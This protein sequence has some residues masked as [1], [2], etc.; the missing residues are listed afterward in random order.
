MNTPSV[1]EHLLPLDEGW[2]LWREFCVRGAGFPATDVLRLACPLS[3]ATSKTML[4]VEQWVNE[5]E[6]DFRSACKAALRESQERGERERASHLRAQ[7]KRSIFQRSPRETHLD[8]ALRARIIN[9]RALHAYL[10]AHQDEVRKAFEKERLNTSKVLRE[11]AR[12]PRFREAVTWQNRGVV[13]TGLDVLLR[14]PPELSNKDTRHKEQLVANYLQRYD[15]KNDTIGFFGP[16]VWGSFSPSGPALEA[17]PGPG[18]VSRRG[19]YFEYW[20]IAALA[21]SLAQRPGM[22][23]LLAPRLMPLSRLEGSVLHTPLGPQDLSP[24]EAAVLSVCDG[25]RSARD[26]AAWLSAQPGMPPATEEEVLAL[27]GTFESQELLRW[28]LEIPTLGEPEVELRERLRRLADPE[29]R[30]PAL[31]A[32]GELEA[33]REDVARS[34]GDAQRLGEAL[35]RLDACFSRLTGRSPSRLAGESGAGRT[36][37]FEDCRRDLELRLGP[38]LLSALSAPLSLLLMGARWCSY[39]LARCYEHE[40]LS[41][42]HSLRAEA[43][44]DELPLLQFWPSAAGLFKRAGGEDPTSVQALFAEYQRKWAELLGLPSDQRQL[45]WTAEELAPRVRKAFAAPHAGWPGARHCSPDIQ[46]AAASVEAVQGGDYVLVLGELHST[47]NTLE[48]GTPWREHP[49]PERLLRALDWDHPTGRFAPAPPEEMAGSRYITPLSRHPLDVTLEY[50]R[51][52]SWR[53]REQTLALAELRVRERAGRLEVVTQDGRRTWDILEALDV[54]LTEANVAPFPALPHTPRLQ[55]DRLVLARE[56]WRFASEA[57][58]FAT[59]ETAEER[60][61]GARRWAQEHGMPRWLFI[62]VSTERKPCFVDLD[63]LIL[64]ELFCKQVRAA[65]QVTV[66]EMLPTVEQC[67]LPDAEGRLYT[68]ELRMVA[69]DGAPWRREAAEPIR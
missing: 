58:S 53:P 6:A 69:V 20:A 3:A 56:T 47:A 37:V 35:E 46:I 44:Q 40:L 21:E 64:V 27:L 39:Q 66:V 32:L 2:F 13:R 10:E 8:F 67:W 33:A 65:E 41:L 19:V 48:Q 51:V 42:F 12:E 16:I 57:L 18:L 36:L 22:R 5:R 15:T 68:S 26:I 43:G 9:A 60:F 11:L 7:L 49:E 38:E 61:V 30:E 25:D 23:P 4:D 28:T 14:T 59:L 62:K 34:A 24:L 1:P 50:D 54:L 45:Q 55:V 29:A 17:R 31:A 63:S 52:P